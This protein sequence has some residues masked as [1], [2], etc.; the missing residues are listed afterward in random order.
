AGTFANP[1]EIIFTSGATSG[2]GTAMYKSGNAVA[3]FGAL[4]S[5]A[6]WEAHFIF[7][8][9]ST[10]TCAARLGFCVAGQEAGDSPT[11]GFWVEYTQLTLPAIRTSHGL[12]GLAVLTLT[13]PPIQL[14]PIPVSTT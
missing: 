14:P 3:S 8:L 12:Q 7:E 1:G 2:N 11:G 9:Q 10:S 4:G 6:G 5:N 13:P